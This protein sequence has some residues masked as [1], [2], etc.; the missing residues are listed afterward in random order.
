MTEANPKILM[1]KF[2]SLIVFAAMA[3]CIGLS[4]CNTTVKDSGSKNDSISS[5]KDSAKTGGVVPPG[6]ETIKDTGDS[7]HK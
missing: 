6:S 5:T 3:A 2:I 1:K 7:I 4:S